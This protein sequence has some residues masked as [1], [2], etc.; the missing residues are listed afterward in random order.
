MIT[1]TCTVCVPHWPCIA[2]EDTTASKQRVYCY[3]ESSGSGS[4]CQ[5]HSRQ[6]RGHI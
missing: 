5:R 3:C 2:E 1:T 6:D 4:R